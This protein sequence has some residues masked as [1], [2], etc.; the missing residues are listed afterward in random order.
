MSLRS[1]NRP[2]RLDACSVSI[3]NYHQDVPPK[4]GRSG[5]VRA[6]GGGFIPLREMTSLMVNICG[7][8]YELE[9]RDAFCTEAEGA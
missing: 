3:N 1:G 9:V 4:T 7:R 6:V 8:G 5:R 2:G